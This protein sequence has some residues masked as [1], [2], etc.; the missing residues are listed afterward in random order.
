MDDTLFLENNFF[1][2]RSIAAAALTMIYS[3]TLKKLKNITLRSR[4]VY[5]NAVLPSTQLV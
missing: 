2:L 5:R 3:L 4:A 1:V